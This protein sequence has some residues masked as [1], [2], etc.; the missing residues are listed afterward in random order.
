MSDFDFASST[1]NDTSINE[2]LDFID[3]DTSD[4]VEPKAVEPGEYKIRITGF[5]KDG[6]GQVVRTSQ[7]GNRF[8]ILTFDIPSEPTSKGLSKIFSLPTE[9]TE[10]KRL[11][12]IKWEL[13]CFKKAFGLV[14]LNLNSMIGREGYAILTLTESEEY[15]Q[16][17]E[18]KKFITGA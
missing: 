3:I 5:R 9:D 14:D 11:N 16:Q 2:S 1:T 18:V 6:Q 17:N 10:P 15:G 13:E 7:S 8:F 12:A 4:A